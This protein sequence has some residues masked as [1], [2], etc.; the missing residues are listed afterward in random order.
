MKFLL[1]WH[2]CTSGKP[3]ECKDEFVT[4][5]PKLKTRIADTPGNIAEMLSKELA[6][7]WFLIFCLHLFMSDHFC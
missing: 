7:V 3:D 6:R 1:I 2:R 5:L 4:L